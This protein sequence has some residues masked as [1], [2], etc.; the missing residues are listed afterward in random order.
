MLRAQRSH[1]NS[2]SSTYTVSPRRMAQPLT[3]QV[4]GCRATYGFT[5]PMAS[6]VSPVDGVSSSSVSTSAGVLAA[7]AMA[8]AGRNPCTLA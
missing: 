2:C 4:R 7:V 8:A 5:Q 6:S 1:V 3:Q